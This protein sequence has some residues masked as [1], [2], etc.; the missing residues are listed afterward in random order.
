MEKLMEFKIKVKINQDSDIFR[1]FE[2]WAESISFEDHESNIPAC[3]ADDIQM[4]EFTESG[5]VPFRPN[6]RDW[7]GTLITVEEALDDVLGR[8]TRNETG[9]LNMIYLDSELEKYVA[10]YLKRIAAEFDGRKI[11]YEILFKEERAHLVFATDQFLYYLD[12]LGCVNMFRT[13]DGTLVSDNE[14]A[15]IGFYES[16]EAIETGDEIKIEFTTYE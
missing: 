8:L 6:C 16:E 9:T 14:F 13:C 2:I 11:P 5:K 3:I 12:E 15:E 7:F 10:L 4:Y 1:H